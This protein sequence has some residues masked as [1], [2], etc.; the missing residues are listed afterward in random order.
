MN[1]IRTGPNE[2]VYLFND[3]ILKVFQNIMTEKIV[4][5]IG[6]LNLY[7]FLVLS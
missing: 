6:K 5:R 2:S 7:T 3:K 1:L 4:I